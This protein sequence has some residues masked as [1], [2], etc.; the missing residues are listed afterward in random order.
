M[1]MG[2]WAKVLLA[3]AVV[4]AAAAGVGAQTVIVDGQPVEVAAMEQDGTV[5]VEAIPFAEALGASAA[6]NSLSKKLIVARPTVAGAVGAEQ[7]EGQ[8]AEMGRAYTIN[9]D[10]PLNFTLISAEF[11]VTR[12]NVGDESVVPQGDEKLLMLHMM[13]QNP[14]E[15]ERRLYWA[16]LELT[17]VDVMNVNREWSQELGVEGTGEPV[18]MDLKP[19][20]KVDLYTAIVVPAKGPVPKLIVKSGEGGVL[21]YDLRAKVTPL[22]ENFRDPE[23]ESGVSARERV[24]PKMYESEYHPMGLFDVKYGDLALPAGGP[25]A[26]APEGMAHMGVGLV[27]RNGSADEQRLY[28]D[29]LRA[30]LWTLDG[31]KIEWDYDLVAGPVWDSVDADLEP[32]QEMEVLAVF[33]VPVGTPLG[34][35]EIREGERGRAYVFDL[36]GAVVQGEEGSSSEESGG[37]GVGEALLEGILGGVF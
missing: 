32:G 4:V 13:V 9:R 30:A 17:A 19:A 24:M 25:Y 31:R 33:E 23:D 35:F 20:Q 10:D 5:Y 16:D 15:R 28:A 8:W 26:S 12:V 36:A 37:G 3:C 2:E 14:Q 29:P 1:M 22:E 7:M 18:D 6:Y 21:R 34:S 27:F 11:T